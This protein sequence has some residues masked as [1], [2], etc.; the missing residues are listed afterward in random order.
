[1]VVK[2]SSESTKTDYGSLILTVIILSSG[3]FYHLRV[4]GIARLSVFF[5]LF[6]FGDLSFLICIEQV[7]V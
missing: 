5:F 4:F 6:L 3:H 7:F 1:M 2:Y